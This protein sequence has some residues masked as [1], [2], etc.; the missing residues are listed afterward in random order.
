M[1]EKLRDLGVVFLLLLAIGC[2]SLALLFQ[3]ATIHY[4]PIDQFGM[5]GATFD[6]SIETGAEGLDGLAVYAPGALTDL[7]LAL[8]GKA[9]IK[10]P[11]YNIGIGIIM[12]L[13]FAGAIYTMFAMI[14]ENNATI[15]DCEAL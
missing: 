12:V 11:Q 6:E 5:L 13:S 1:N 14:R 2:G 8:R 7:G 10:Y 9:W 3:P 15:H 4:E